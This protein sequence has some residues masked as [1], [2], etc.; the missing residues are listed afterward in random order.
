MD[1]RDELSKRYTINGCTQ[2]H[3]YAER[4]ARALVAQRRESFLTIVIAGCL[5]LV[6]AACVLAHVTAHYCFN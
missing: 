2:F 6:L 5:L 3:Y 1:A 4:S